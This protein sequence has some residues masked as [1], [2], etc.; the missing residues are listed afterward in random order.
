[1]KKY[2][3]LSIFLCVMLYTPMAF[4]TEHSICNPK[5]A[6]GDLVLPGPAGMCF[7]F[8]PVL[9]QGKGPFGG[10]EFIMGDADSDNYST[11]PTKAVVGG[12]FP[13]DGDENMWLFYMGKYEVTR[14]QYKA[15]MGK[16]PAGITDADTHPQSDALPIT[17]IS[18]F[19]ALAFIDALN[20]WLY[21][22]SLELLPKSGNYPGFIRLPSEIEWEFAARGGRAVKASV[23]EA[24]MPYTEIPPEEAK[25]NA[26]GI[27]SSSDVINYYEW[28]HEISHGKLQTIG[29]LAPNAL[30]L[31]DM[32]GNVQ[33]MTSTHYQFEYYQGRSGGFTSRGNSFLSQEDSLHVAQRNEEPYYYKKSG[34][35]FV[36]NAKI[37]LGLRLVISA[38]LN[39]GRKSSAV[40]KAA[41]E[42]YRA[43]VGSQSPAALSV[44]PTSTQ[45]RVSVQDALARLEK[46][47][48]DPA[49]SAAI[50]QDLA[51]TRAAME[52]SLRVRSK[53]DSDAAKNWLR[54]TVFWGQ[55]IQINIQKRT[56]F[57]R[58]TKNMYQDNASILA[59]RT[60]RSNDMRK[61]IEDMLEAYR[62]GVV[63][64]GELPQKHILEA[65]ESRKKE[66]QQKL[67]DKKLPENVVRECLQVLDVVT[68]NYEYFVKHKRANVPQWHLE[69][70]EISN[71]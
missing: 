33:E 22:N 59:Q 4:A 39:T 19:D 12:S 49:V 69:F 11:P 63:S 41:W 3:F 17:H 58:K 40:A 1:M 43:G 67:I 16:L 57:D 7:A 44:A 60:Q 68:K 31:H 61:N 8:R 34:K 24:P 35:D 70:V 66:E 15:I 37:T 29:K 26:S 6:E 50:K 23:F 20:K 64:M 48:N 53:A 30:G 42:D 55:N 28:Y 52:E 56:V 2:L 54:Q 47:R 25:A 14:G 21:S 32:L 36:P 62:D 5:V 10:Q 13:V 9:V 38:P 27:Q 46:L 65:I 71:K 18:Y 45:E 51:L